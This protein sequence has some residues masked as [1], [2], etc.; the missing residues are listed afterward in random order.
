MTHLFYS[1]Y[2]LEHVRGGAILEAEYI[3]ANVNCEKYW[4]ENPQFEDITPITVHLNSS[5]TL[6]KIENVE[7]LLSYGHN[8]HSNTLYSFYLP[9]EKILYGPDLA[10]VK[11]FPPAGM[12]DIYYTDVL[13]SLDQNSKL[14]FNTYIPSHGEMGSKQD[15]LGYQGL[16]VS[17]RKK[18]LGA[19]VEVMSLYVDTESGV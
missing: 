3:L 16:I 19:D 1:H 9:K 18:V 8:S 7:I 15:F 12:P 4:L 10:F 17:T 5:D 14:D 6:I 13:K 2:H 11:M